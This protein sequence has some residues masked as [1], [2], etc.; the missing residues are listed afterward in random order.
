MR[1]SINKKCVEE[2]SLKIK[3]QYDIF[4]VDRFNESIVPKLD[5]LGLFERLDLVTSSLKTYLP[6]DYTES[7]NILLKVLDD[8]KGFIILSLSNY[9]AYYGMDYFDNSMNALAIMTKNFSSEFAIRHFLIK[10]PRKSLKYLREWVKDSQPEV[11]RLVS[12]GTRPR[13]PWGLRLQHFVKDPT[14][15]LE[16]LEIL[17]DDEE[18][19]VR[20]SVANNLND[21]SKDH[22]ELVLDILKKWSKSLSKETDWVIKHSLRTL[23]KKGNTSALEILGFSKEPKIK[24]DNISYSK[25]VELGSYLNFSFDLSS[26]IKYKQKL[27][28]DFVIYHLKAN[29]KKSPKVFKLKNMELPGNETI[30]INKKHGI[31]LISTRKYYSGEHGLSIKI[32]GKEF[33][34]GNFDLSV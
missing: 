29:G 21:I 34:F 5:P 6:V 26:E 9:V 20:R 10:Y 13:L 4:D 1:N 33:K 12:E 19:Y 30:T 2:L 14:P 25:D 22:P 24:I 16:F 15:I 11:R 28:V 8:E 17:K 7:L 31:R 27:V 32:N 3:K 18:L 23:V